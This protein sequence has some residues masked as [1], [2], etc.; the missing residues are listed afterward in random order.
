[1]ALTQLP[2]AAAAAHWLGQRVTGTLSSDS[3]QLRAG[4]GFIAWPGLSNDAR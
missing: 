1:M 4:D 3:R 2:T